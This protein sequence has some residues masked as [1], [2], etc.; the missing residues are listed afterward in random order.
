MTQAIIIIAE[1]TCFILIFSFKKIAARM[2]KNTGVS[3]DIT[4]V[5]KTIP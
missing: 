1:I 3:I 5:V 2:N 4:M